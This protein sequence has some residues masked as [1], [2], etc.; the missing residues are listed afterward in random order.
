MSKNTRHIDIRYF[1]IKQYVERGEV[2]V[3][4][5]ATEQMPANVLTKLLQGS[6]F[7]YERKLLTNGTD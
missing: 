6:Q 2:V 7:K 3:E 5:L 4:K 1:W